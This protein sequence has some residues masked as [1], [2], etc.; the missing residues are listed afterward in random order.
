MN[1]IYVDGKIRTESDPGIAA[2]LIRKG[3]TPLVY[4]PESAPL[5]YADPVPETRNGQQVAVAYAL[6]TADERHSAA[7]SALRLRCHAIRQAERLRRQ[8]GG[9][10]ANGHTY[11]SDRE[12]SIPLLT[13]AVISAQMALA[14]G[15]EVAEAFAAAL[16]DGWR[17]T[18]GVPVVTTAMGILGLHE[19]FVAWGA[20]CDRASQLIAADIDAAQDIAA[21][22]A[23]IATISRDPRWP[24]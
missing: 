13:G 16:G 5:G 24:A 15:P 23:I 1:L 9:F 22:E 7:L 6:G 11:A 14:K 10:H 21:M 8:T 20:A 19:A 3:W 17:D 2:T 12:E 4:D 18:A